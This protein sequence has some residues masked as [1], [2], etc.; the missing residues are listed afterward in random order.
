LD[1]CERCGHHKND[2]KIQ[3]K[4]SNETFKK[5]INFQK[6]QDLYDLLKM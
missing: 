5:T 6:F 2:A 4:D 3:K 1:I